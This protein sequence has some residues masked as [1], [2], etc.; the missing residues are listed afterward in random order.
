MEEEYLKVCGLCLKGVIE[1]GNHTCPE[2]CAV[3]DETVEMTVEE[4]EEGYDERDNF[5]Y[6][7]KNPLQQLGFM[8]DMITSLQERR[9]MLKSK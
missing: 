3:E 6:A 1:T 8:A 7:L 5:F 9:D 2:C 4:Y